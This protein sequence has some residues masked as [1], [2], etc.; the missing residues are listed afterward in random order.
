MAR[1]TCV[2]SFLLATANLHA[3]PNDTTEATANGTSIITANDL[4]ADSTIQCD[5]QNLRPPAAWQVRA[6]QTVVSA[7]TEA[8]R[9]LAQR[10]NACV[11]TS[12]AAATGQMANDDERALVAIPQAELAKQRGDRDAA[13]ATYREAMELASLDAS[14]RLELVRRLAYL[15]FERQEWADVLRL[16][17]TN[18]SCAAWTGDALTLRGMAYEGLFA[19]RLALESFEGAINLYQLQ[20]RAL[21]TGLQGR[22]QA[23]A[24]RHDPTAANA[25]DVIP[26]VRIA[27]NYPDLALRRRREGW[28]QMQFDITDMGTVAN[29]R[30]VSSSDPMFDEAALTA[31]RQWRYTPKFD[32]GLPVARLGVQTIIRFELEP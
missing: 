24:A 9:C 26:A 5:F 29:A 2:A 6:Q 13:E 8:N 14:L 20:G 3:Q 18:Y 23:L 10:D 27:P 1:H 31:L 4:A 7:V 28:V 32:S 30:A 17:N 16:L 21:P 22:Y 12:L 11:E 15:R 19:T 25:A